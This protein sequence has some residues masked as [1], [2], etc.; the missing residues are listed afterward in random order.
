MGNGTST[1]INSTTYSYLSVNGIGIVRA[2]ST[3]TYISTTLT[4]DDAILSL[5]SQTSRSLDAAGTQIGAIFFNADDSSTGQ[6]YS[7]KSAIV[8]QSQGTWNGSVSPMAT[9]FGMTKGVSTTM[10]SVMILSNGAG[11]SGDVYSGKMEGSWQAESL[12]VTEALVTSAI[13]TATAT[14]APLAG[15]TYKTTGTYAGTCTITLTITGAMTIGNECYMYFGGL[16]VGNN[17]TL[18]YPD[19]GGLTQTI[20]TTCSSKRNLIIR[21]ASSGFLVVG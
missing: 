13:T 18:N 11:G 3:E 21:R 4:V 19:P 16:L 2:S 8:T 7:A 1:E 20:I 12:I 6:V 15:K 10:D 9:I 17:V 5:G 14:L